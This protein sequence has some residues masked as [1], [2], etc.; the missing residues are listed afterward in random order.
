M[1][2]PHAK[3]N[4]LSLGHPDFAT[5][6][7]INFVKTGDISYN[8]I[9]NSREA[10]IAYSDYYIYVIYTLFLNGKFNIEIQ[11]N[12]QVY[13]CLLSAFYNDPYFFELLL[14]KISKN[15]LREVFS[16]PI[17]ISE[18]N[19]QKNDHEDEEYNPEHRDFILTLYEYLNN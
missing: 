16:D 1:H 13:Y 4:T 9:Y 15:K 7:I 11:K 12:E 17:V 3:L 6:E 14:N 18:T 8:Y 5:P 19:E 10:I 2:A